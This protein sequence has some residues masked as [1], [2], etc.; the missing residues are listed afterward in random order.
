MAHRASAGSCHP[1]GH[2]G[3]PVLGQQRAWTHTGGVS[4]GWDLPVTEAHSP[5]VS[6]SRGDCV[7]GT[8]WTAGPWATLRTGVLA[9]GASPPR[10]PPRP[11]LHV[12]SGGQAHTSPTRTLAALAGEAAHTA[13]RPPAQYGKHDP[14]GTGAAPTPTLHR[15]KHTLAN[16]SK[17]TKD[18]NHRAGGG[19]GGKPHWPLRPEQSSHNS[20]ASAVGGGEAGAGP[21]AGWEGS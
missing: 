5:S 11:G 21:A 15:H 16:I 18:G 9:T 8:L 4:V 1:R 19:R 17:N 14:V 6:S 7:S 13:P 3:R 12:P 20:P 2:P 10:T